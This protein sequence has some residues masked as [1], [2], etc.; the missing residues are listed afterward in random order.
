MTTNFFMAVQL[1]TGHP[2]YTPPALWI[3]RA[4]VKQELALDDKEQPYQYDVAV[5]TDLWFLADAAADISK[6]R[7]V[8]LPDDSRA[9]Q[10][11]RYRLETAAI[12]A[13]HNPKLQP[14]EM[15]DDK[16]K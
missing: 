11:F 2:N 14:A 15:P 13:Y 6:A 4:E 8:D 12:S 7:R 3:G 1:E 10:R 16:T 9:G 5:I